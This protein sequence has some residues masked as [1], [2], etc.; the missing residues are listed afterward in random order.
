MIPDVWLIKQVVKFPRRPYRDVPE[1]NFSNQSFEIGI[2]DC[3]NIVSSLLEGSGDTQIRVDVTGA[4]NRDDGNFHAV[5][6][7]ALRS[8]W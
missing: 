3:P 6:L 1:P 2:C 7:R 4:S 8:R 5:Q